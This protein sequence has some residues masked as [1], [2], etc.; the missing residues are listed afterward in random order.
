MAQARSTPAAHDTELVWQ[1]DRLQRQVDALQEEREAL[2]QHLDHMQ[3]ALMAAKERGDSLLSPTEKRPHTAAALLEALACTC[4]KCWTA[5]WTPSR[6]MKYNIAQCSGSA[7]SKLRSLQCSAGV[8][9]L[10]IATQEGQARMQ[11]AVR[12]ASE[13]ASRREREA[14]D[15][16]VIAAEKDVLLQSQM[17]VF[18]LIEPASGSAPKLSSYYPVARTASAC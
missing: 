13:E 3:D 18:T 4:H 16:R 15:R 14:A 8:E 11:E 12:I 7:C 10:R 6:G 1:A 9:E 2:A 17:W 5:S